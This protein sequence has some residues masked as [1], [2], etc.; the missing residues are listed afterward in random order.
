M[1]NKQKFKPV[2]E[3]KTTYLKTYNL[4]I[5]K[6]NLSFKSLICTLMLGSNLGIALLALES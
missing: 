2:K 4:K 5:M 3:W 1:D 6:I